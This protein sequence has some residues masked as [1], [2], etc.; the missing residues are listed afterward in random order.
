[1]TC[2][3]NITI[4]L[5]EEV[6]LLT[7]KFFFYNDLKFSIEF[8]ISEAEDDD[9][10][11]KSF[12]FLQETG[13]SLDQVL[14]HWKA[15]FEHRRR[16]LLN[17]KHFDIYSYLSKY[18]AFKNDNG[19]LLVYFIIIFIIYSKKNNITDSKSKFYTLIARLIMIRV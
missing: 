10:I 16:E 6:N 3:C 15:T 9:E 13:K 12:E 5:F 4:L 8:E 19:N 17:A 7:K 1:M 14:V 11:K 2:H 18:S